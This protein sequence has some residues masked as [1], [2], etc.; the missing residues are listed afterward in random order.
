MSGSAGDTDLPDDREDQIL[1]RDAGREATLHFDGEGPGTSLQQALCRQH[2]ADFGR[3]DAEGEG[4]EGPMGRRVAVAADDGLAG[5]RRTLFW[6]DHVHDA[7]LV[8]AE[9]QQFDA[10]LAAVLFQF[11]HLARGGFDLDRHA[12]EDFIGI[13]RRGVIHRRQRAIDAAD[14]EAQRA[15]QREGL[16]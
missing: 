9:A 15:Q 16:R 4:A 1:R 6:A 12:A 2:M 14:L 7:A 13:G 3:A 10:E 8:A 11:L 5:L